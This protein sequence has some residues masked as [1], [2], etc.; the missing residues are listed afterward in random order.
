MFFFT[1]KLY[2]IDRIA[3]MNTDTGNVLRRPGKIHAERPVTR[4]THHTQKLAKPKE[5]ITK[6]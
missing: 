3:P 5:K 6:A 4:Q 2:S 1:G